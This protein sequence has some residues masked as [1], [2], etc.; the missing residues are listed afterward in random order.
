MTFAYGAIT[1]FGQPFQ[2]CSARQIAT[3]RSLGIVPT[4]APYF[5][6][7]YDGRE[8]LTSLS[9]HSP[10]RS[11]L[12][13]KE[14]RRAPER[15]HLTTATRHIEISKFQAALGCSLFARRY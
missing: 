15:Y 12:R 8:L 1:L 13:S 7:S 9:V 5:V 11:S 14:R 2:D 3:F 10:I 4:S 6:R